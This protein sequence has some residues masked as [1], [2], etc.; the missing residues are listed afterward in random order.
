MVL[1]LLQDLMDILNKLADLSL[2]VATSNVGAGYSA[3]TFTNVPLYNITGSGSGAQATITFSGGGQ[4]SGTPTIT[5]TGNGYSVGDVLGITTSSV[6]KGSGGT[7]SVSAI[8][9]L[10]Y[11]ILNKCSG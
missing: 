5:A 10:E 9:G 11:F 1:Y 4:V 2:T 8:S 6:A 7:I 3:G